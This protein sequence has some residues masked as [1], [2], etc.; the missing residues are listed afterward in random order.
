MPYSFRC[1]ACGFLDSGANAGTSGRPSACRACGA[2]A[3][4]HP[5]TGL[6]KL[7][8]ENWEHLAEC[9]PARLAELGLSAADVVRH[10]ALTR[11]EDEAADRKRVEANRAVLAAKK[12]HW[13][14]NE[15]AIRARH[16]ELVADLK[17]I[18]RRQSP[19]PDRERS[20]IAEIDDLVDSEFT[21]R[22]EAHLAEL[23]RRLKQGAAGAGQVTRT[24]AAA[25]GVGVR[26]F[27]TQRS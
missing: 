11:D 10:E 6:K 14:A 16:A 5:E 9:S 24:A 20:A 8:P 17:K 19:D 23:D 4:F 27:T 7:V 13:K 18:G 3:V 22:D 25:D 15:S 12:K 21:D 2:G 26:N 1:R